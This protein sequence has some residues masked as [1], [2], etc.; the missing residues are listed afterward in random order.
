MGNEEE[1]KGEEFLQLQEEPTRDSIQGREVPTTWDEEYKGQSEQ[2]GDV[3]KTLEFIK[4]E[5]H[6]EETDAHQAENDAQ[7]EFEDSMKDLKEEQTT[8]EEN[9]AKHQLKLAE[10]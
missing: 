2:G 5:S 4:E 6:K 10:T 9:L 3:I 7:H 8:L 1:P